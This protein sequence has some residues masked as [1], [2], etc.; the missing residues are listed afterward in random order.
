MD[1]LHVE[2]AYGT[3]QSP[4]GSAYQTESDSIRLRSAIIVQKTDFIGR[5]AV[6]SYQRE[7]V[8]AVRRAALSYFFKAACIAGTLKRMILILPAS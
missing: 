1:L 7:A 2:G 8:V 3:S 4:L 6:I 5:P